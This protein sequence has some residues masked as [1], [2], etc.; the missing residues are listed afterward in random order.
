M[1]LGQSW[2]LHGTR[3]HVLGFKFQY[4]VLC[5]EF[6]ETLPS[7]SVKY[8]QQSMYR[9]LR[10]NIYIYKICIGNMYI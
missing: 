3:V 8:L 9:Y 1:K 10:W 4:I 2:P 5:F 6:I 7:M